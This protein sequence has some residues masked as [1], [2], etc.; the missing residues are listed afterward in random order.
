MDIFARAHKEHHD[1]LT[2]PSAW[3]CRTA[4]ITL[5]KR[6]TGRADLPGESFP[7]VF[8]WRKLCKMKN[9]ISSQNFILLISYHR[10]WGLTLPAC[11]P[12]QLVQ[13]CL[14]DVQNMDWKKMAAPF[15]WICSQNETKT[16]ACSASG[17]LIGVSSKKTEKLE[18]KAQ[19]R[20]FWQCGKLNVVI[21]YQR[22]QQCPS[23][24]EFQLQM[25]L[26]MHSNSSKAFKPE[27]THTG[28]ILHCV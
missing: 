11:Q 27:I 13:V 3:T 19:G 2:V 15:T 9:E 16:R 17:C 8:S 22:E 23:L 14:G 28:K 24:H 1:V 26:C 5:Q 20:K 18:G 12:E 10:T 6:T 21:I 4:Y 7:V 25:N